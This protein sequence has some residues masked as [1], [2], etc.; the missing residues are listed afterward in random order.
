MVLNSWIHTVLFV[1]LIYHNYIH[2]LHKPAGR[3][4][5]ERQFCQPPW[6]TTNFHFHTN[7][8]RELHN[9]HPI[10]LMPWRSCQVQGWCR[11]AGVLQ[12]HRLNLDNNR[13][14]VE[15]LIGFQISFTVLWLILI[16]CESSWHNETHIRIYTE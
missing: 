2:V 12:Q 10:R 11:P 7:E 1:E 9:W 15:W 6:D 5:V 8:H 3:E 4:L 13:V 16:N 14:N